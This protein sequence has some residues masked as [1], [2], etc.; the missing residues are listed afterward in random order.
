MEENVIEIWRDI[1]GYEGYYQVSNLG[2]VRSLP[3]YKKE[4]SGRKYLMN[5]K[6]LKQ[7]FTST[8][9]KKVELQINN[10]RKTYKTHRLVAK[11]FLV[12]TYNKPHVNH[13]D[14]NPLNNVVDNLEWC[15]QKE[16]VQHA[17]E[18]GLKVYPMDKID[19]NS[20]IKDYLTGTTSSVCKKYGI[21]REILYDILK[22]HKI[23]RHRN[24]KYSVNLEDVS[25]DIKS[26]MRNIDIAKKY[27][28]SRGL[29]NTRK[30]QMKK[31]GL[32]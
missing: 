19:H 21:T 7:S 14:G 22:M 20:L 27:N 8:G 15:T 31:E 29:I 24:A 4:K 5:G 23:S 10:E 13:K 28:C 26:G 25:K 32:L 12:N 2:E 17:R 16:N 30:Y 3:R 9:Y 1:P 18:N 11:A 6:I